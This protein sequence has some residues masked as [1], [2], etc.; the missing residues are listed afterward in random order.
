MDDSW[1]SGAQNSVLSPLC[2]G[3]L[4]TFWAVDSLLGQWFCGV[5]SLGPRPPT[6]CWFTHATSVLPSASVFFLLFLV[7][8]LPSLIAKAPLREQAGGREDPIIP[9]NVST[10]S[11]SLSP[12]PRRAEVTR[13]EAWTQ[14]RGHSWGV[15]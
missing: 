11:P 3:P 12:S 9:R 8:P 2:R 6:G 15:N 1:H 5:H 7:N 14:D 13:L 10:A 4:A